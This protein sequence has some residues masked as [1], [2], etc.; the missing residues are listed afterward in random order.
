MYVFY[1]IIQTLCLSLHCSGY[2]WDKSGLAGTRSGSGGTGNAS[3]I[4]LAVG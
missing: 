2:Y 4:L 3:M 1:I